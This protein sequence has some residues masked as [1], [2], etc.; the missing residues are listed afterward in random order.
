MHSRFPESMQS[1]FLF[2]P[3]FVRIAHSSIFI[4]HECRIVTDFRGAIAA[5]VVV[6]FAIF[7]SYSR[8]DG[9]GV[10]FECN[11]FVWVNII[12]IVFFLLFC[13]V[14]MRTA[15]HW[16][17]AF[18]HLFIYFQCCAVLL[19]WYP[20]E[21]FVFAVIFM[22]SL[23]LLCARVFWLSDL[24]SDSNCRWQVS[25]RKWEGVGERERRRFF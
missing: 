3:L 4:C 24:C 6:G 17:A 22:S 21:F 11:C 20:C 1:L 23:W 8:S 16:C 25:V 19:G 14:K 5:V 10:P 12:S 7:F 2:L 15:S 9:I 18:F 13:G